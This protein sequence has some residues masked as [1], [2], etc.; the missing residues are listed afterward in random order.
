M[1]KKLKW[2]LADRP[3]PS[4][5]TNLMEKEIISKDE[6][7]EILF[8]EE[9]EETKGKKELESEIKFLRELVERLAKNPTTIVETIRYI[10][11]PYVHWGWYQPY[12]VWCTNL[13]SN[14]A[15]LTYANGITGTLTSGSTNL[16]NTATSAMQSSMSAQAGTAGASSPFS[17]IKT[18]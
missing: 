1:T 13:A 2:R 18:F 4:E 16:M 7:R 15:Q 8:S 9:T 14:A 11:Q 3:T 12:Q 5:V 6:A 10:Q 17:K